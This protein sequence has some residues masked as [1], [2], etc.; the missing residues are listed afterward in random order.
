MAVDGWHWAAAVLAALLLSVLVLLWYD[1][2]RERPGWTL[3]MATKRALLAAP[4]I[5]VG[6]AAALLLPLWVGGVL[7]L[8]PLVIIAIMAMAD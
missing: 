3:S 6:F 4:A 8:A 2:L 1:T 7:I 5:P